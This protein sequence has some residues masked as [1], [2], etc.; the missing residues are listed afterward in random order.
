MR[1]SS[2][3]VSH[4]PVQTTEPVR[5]AIVNDYEIVVSGLATM[6]EPYADRVR[7]VE[8]DAGLP[9]LS[10]VDVVLYDTFARADGADLRI[11]DLIALGSAKVVVFTWGSHHALIARAIAQGAAGYLSKSLS[12][13][14]VVTALEEVRDGKIV[15]GPHV[16]Q[17]EDPG[18][19]DWPGRS[20]GLTPREAEILAFI[21]Q[22]L[23]N[24]EIADRFHLS[25]NSVKTFIRSAYQKIAVT[26]RAQAV[27]WGIQ[28]GFTPVE[29]RSLGAEDPRWQ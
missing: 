5:L 13:E 22:G 8:L 15:T 24:H 25:I 1:G 3:L 26:R 9:V 17:G 20:A 23:T 27:S 28:N 14:E 29:F 16:Q 12:A 6:L 19:G 21:V 7:I 10:D 18:D 11:D 4:V 2:K